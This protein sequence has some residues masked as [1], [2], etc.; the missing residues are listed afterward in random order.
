MLLFSNLNKYVLGNFDPWN[1]CLGNETINFQGD[2]TDISAE[3]DPLLGTHCY[4]LKHVW[5]LS[6]DDTSVHIL[7][8]N[9]PISSKYI[10][11]RAVDPL[12]KLE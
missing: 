1:V 8:R 9:I 11:Q 5:I 4:L 3:K 12:A 6:H 7:Y 2:L 10:Y